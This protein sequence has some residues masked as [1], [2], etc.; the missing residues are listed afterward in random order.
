MNSEKLSH[1]W[2]IFGVLIGMPETS[3]VEIIN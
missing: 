1:F 2:F 3:K